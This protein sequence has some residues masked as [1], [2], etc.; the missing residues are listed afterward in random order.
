M[1]VS[2]IIVWANTNSLVKMNPTDYPNK[3]IDVDNALLKHT[4]FLIDQLLQL[5]PHEILVMDNEGS[6]H[7]LC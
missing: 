6:F 7:H 4:L 1:K 5:Q 2:Y 3:N